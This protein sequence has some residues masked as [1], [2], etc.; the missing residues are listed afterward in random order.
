MHVQIIKVQASEPLYLKEFSLGSI[1]SYSVSSV[2][3]FL[4]N[5]TKL[6]LKFMKPNCFCHTSN[7]R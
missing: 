4:A 2:L 1:C 3:N 5:Q 6:N 7:F